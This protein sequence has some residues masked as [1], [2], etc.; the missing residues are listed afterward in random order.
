ML[1][2]QKLYFVIVGWM[3]LAC[4]SLSK[5]LVVRK[6][7]TTKA[8]SRSRFH[9]KF[10]VAAVTAPD[11]KIGMKPVP[12]TVLS[13]FLGAGKTT[14]L[15]HLLENANG[16]K[17]GL[18]VNDMASV[19]ID[20]KLIKTKTF[21]KYDEVDTMELQNGC[22]CCSL[23]DDMIAS[24]SKLV[25][26]STVRGSDYDHIIVECSGIAE[27]RRIREVF[28]E[29]EDFQSPLINKVKLDTLITLVDAKTFRDLFGSDSTL[30]SNPELAAREED[31]EGK[32]NLETSN[33]DRKITELLLEQ[34][35]CADVVLINKCDLLNDKSEI[36]L[37]EDVITNI[38]PTC[39]TKSCVK[40]MVDEPLKLIGSA[41][42]NG[43]ASWGVLDE[44]RQAVQ[45]VNDRNKKQVESSQ[46]CEPGCNDPSHNHDHKHEHDHSHSMS[47][48]CEPGCND[49]S[50]NHDHKHEH[51]HSHSILQ[52]CEPG[53]NDPSHNHDH[54]HD[55]SHAATQSCEPGCN[56][57]THNHDHSHSHH[58]DD[59]IT[60]AKKRFGITSFVYARRKPFHPIRFSLFLQS[61]GQ[62]SVDGISEW[63]TMTSESHQDDNE[64]YVKS[65]KALL[66]S[67]GFVWMATSSKAAYYISHA[68]QYLELSVLG[69]WWA[70]IK[71]EQWPAG[72]ESEIAREFN[73]EHGDRR[74]EI[75]F[76]GQFNDNIDSSQ[77]TFEEVLDSCL[78]T[79]EEMRQY[80]I[81][82][83]LGDE[84]LRELYFGQTTV[85]K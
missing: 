68:G 76:I 47:Q 41:H 14:Y 83:Q 66:R 11:T 64:N 85:K 59:D 69:R 63:S 53:C 35:E 21:G 57:P 3:I 20:S 56:D 79:D 15:Q 77:K 9:R 72:L 82:S 16:V 29:A 1:R 40:G 58:H 46:S 2:N 37:V 73:G 49:P 55:H 39:V 36:K 28:Q 26:L 51:D 22:V 71:K 32:K 33:G 38:N 84:K 52:S 24:V 12:I 27:P 61:I 13:G 75:V 62:V 48:S 60:T 30:I 54:K 10:S 45:L 81:T 70:D 8:F 19:N 50:H 34:V 67:K 6:L 80:E 74:Q 7:S 65:K 18:I 44:H 78:L 5:S 4:V 25:S 42:G 31:I 43:M 17:F 23:A